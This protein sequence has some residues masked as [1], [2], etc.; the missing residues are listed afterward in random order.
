LERISK[1]APTPL[2]PKGIR[3]LSHKPFFLPWREGIKGRGRDTKAVEQPPR[4][5]FRVGLEL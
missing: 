3:R 1:S 2:L 4:G 5:G